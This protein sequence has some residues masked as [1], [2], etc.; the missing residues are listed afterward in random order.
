M[1]AYEYEKFIGDRISQL[2][3]DRKLSQRKLSS[4]LGQN[5]SYIG[6]IESHNSFPSVPSLLFI[7]EYFNISPSEFFEVDNSH[8]EILKELISKLSKL[9]DS[10]LDIVKQLI[11]QFEQNSH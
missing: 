9:K 8:P 11:A 3:K 4:D 2:R 5:G 1:N 6:R 7:C 10:E